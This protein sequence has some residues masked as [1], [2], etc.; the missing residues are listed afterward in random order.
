MKYMKKLLS[1]MFLCTALGGCNATMGINGTVV[2]AEGTGSVQG[3]Y[4]NECRIVIDDE[5]S[6][7][8]SGAWLDQGKISITGGGVYKLTGRAEKGVSIDT[9][10]PVRLILSGAEVSASEGSGIISGKG[11]LTIFAAEG[12]NN[13]IIGGNS[14]EGEGFGVYSSGGLILCG[15]GKLSVAGDKGIFSAEDV[16]I[17]NLSLDVTARE[18]GI[19]AE[20]ICINGGE[21]YIKAGKNGLFAKKNILIKSGKAA[22]VGAAAEKIT[23]EGGALLIL[24]EASENSEGCISFI[25]SVKSG[26]RITVTKEDTTVFELTAP[27][28]F[29]GILVGGG[30]ECDNY[31]VTV[32]GKLL[33]TAQD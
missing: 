29:E 7:N 11:K 1:M 33:N 32:G 6:I 26:E 4:A 24:G 15:G 19:S 18:S 23:S 28:D 3:S 21:T 25:E 13:S 20:A 14:E 8:G 12:T 2:S 16:E 22:A 17:G 9:A 10:E 5:I 31:C 27:A 30:S